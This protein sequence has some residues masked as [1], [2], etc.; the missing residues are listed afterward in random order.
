MDP[1]LLFLQARLS[2]QFGHKVDIYHEDG[3]GVLAVKHGDPLVPQNVI[4][5]LSESA[6][7]SII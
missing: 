1:R 4:F 7:Y 6:L 2:Q 3:K 5:S